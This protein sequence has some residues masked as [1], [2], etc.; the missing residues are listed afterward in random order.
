MRNLSAKYKVIILLVVFIAIAVVMFT[1][2]YDI[3]GGRNQALSEGASK[4]RLE[5]DILQR[6]QRS[7]EQAKKDLA[8]L[9]NKP[10][11]PQELF[12]KDTKVVK[13]IKILEDNAAKYGVSMSLTIAGNTKTAPKVAGV[14]TELFTVPYVLTL[15]GSFENLMNYVQATEHLPFVSYTKVVNMSASADNKIRLIMNSDFY[16]RKWNS[17]LNSA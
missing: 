6:E 7:A 4:Q 8:E 2:G 1:F 3:L 15:E 10:F 17:H 11:P 13:E 12:S 9:E 5:Y 16:I 14:S